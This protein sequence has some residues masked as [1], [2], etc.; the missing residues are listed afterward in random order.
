M[1][2]WPMSCGWGAGGRAALHHPP[3]ARGCRPRLQLSS[4]GGSGSPAQG[5]SP[6]PELAGHT[7]SSGP[8]GAR[9]Y[10]KNPSATAVVG[11]ELGRGSVHRLSHTT[12]A[13]E[14]LTSETTLQG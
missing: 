6:I 14:E 11:R 13:N 2:P 12:A 1:A 8:P 9:K 5:T 3:S 4:Q 10:P 7:M